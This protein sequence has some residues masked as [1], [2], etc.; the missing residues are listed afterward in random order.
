MA[1]KRALAASHSSQSNSQPTPSAQRPTK[2]ARVAPSSPSLASS[3]L[4]AEPSTLASVVPET[5]SL[6]ASAPSAQLPPLPAPVKR[7]RTEGSLRR[8]S[9]GHPAASAPRTDSALAGAGKRPRTRPGSTLAGAKVGGK[10]KDLRDRVEAEE[11]WVRRSKGAQGGQGL[12]F[13]GYLKMGVGAFVERGCTTLTVNAMGAAIPLA[14]SLAMAIRDAIPGGEPS[15]SSSPD[16]DPEDDER[17]EEESIVQMQVRTGSKTVA[18][19]VTPDDEDEDLVYQSRTKS[20]LHPRPARLPSPPVPALKRT[21]DPPAMLNFLFG[22]SSAQKK[23]QRAAHPFPSSS[24]RSYPPGGASPY[25]AGHDGGYDDVVLGGNAH[26]GGDLGSSGMAAS[27]T[28]FSAPAASDGAFVGGSTSSP[29]PSTHATDPAG[30]SAESSYPPLPSFSR[31][32]SSPSGSARYPPPAATLARLRAVLDAQSPAL[33]DTLSPPLPPSDPAL[34]SLRATLAP[35]VLPPAVVESYLVHDG[36]EPLSS[37]GG[38]AAGGARVG[39]LGLVYGLWWL[40]LEQ[41]ETEWRFWR[42]LEHAGGLSGPG[43]AGDAFGASVSGVRGGRAHP[44]EREEEDGGERGSEAEGMGA[45]PEGWVRARYSH[46]G[47]LPLLTDRCG[48]YIGVDLD[49]P[50]PSP[51]SPTSP[52][53]V[54]PGAPGAKARTYGQP[55]QV[56]AFGREIDTK[57]VLFPGDGPGGWARFLAAFVDDVERGEFARLGERPGAGDGG[58]DEREWD[59]ERQSG[60]VLRRRGSGSGS[61]GEE[62]GWADGDGLGDRGYF[63]TDV[64]G[65]EVVGSGPGARS[66]QTWV[67]RAE[68][69]RLADKLDLPGGIIGLLCERS[70]RKWRSLGVGSATHQPR[71][72]LPMT[73]PGQPLSVV[74]PPSSGTGVEAVQGEED[75]PQSATTER[76][77]QAQAQE[78]ALPAAEGST[79]VTS[80]SESNVSL[81]LSPPSPTKA[82]TAP[83]AS[84]PSRSSHDSARSHKSSASGASSAYLRESPRSHPSARQQQQRAPRRP[85]PPPAALFLPTFTDLDFSDAVSADPASPQGQRP[86]LVPKASWLLS[87]GRDAVANAAAGALSRLSIGSSGTPTT[88]SGALLPTS[89]SREESEENGIALAERN[90]SRTALVSGGGGGSPTDEMSG[91]PVERVEV[92][93]HRA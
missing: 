23:K 9:S 17:N 83:A 74:V 14:L 79:V 30:Y 1:S 47:W 44:Y 35:Y 34:L 72:I 82:G 89:L 51:S 69:R 15:S 31:P 5:P 88:A 18:D 65:E 40:P 39:G 7:T 49:P 73:V 64:Y 53:H 45:F 46:P 13:A 63:E 92:V 29:P 87:D 24:S 52:T 33:H 25:G 42:A 67:L 11:M 41:V 59:E 6:P 37:S 22:G 55:G 28:S 10:A 78:A 62:D 26:G 58:V 54:A 57:V 80:A 68:Y 32:S 75:E 27:R 61:S 56:I 2:R 66:A 81:V 76:P 85:P 71:G 3:Q 48:N 84:L 8:L 86:P 20:T 36:Q 43:L 4:P 93:A 38:G 70:R 19:E 77:S 16:S 90:S 91:S 50:P 12:G 21:H 60:G